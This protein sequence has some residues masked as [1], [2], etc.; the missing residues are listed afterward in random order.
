MVIDYVWESIGWY[1]VEYIDLSWRKYLYMWNP[2]AGQPGLHPHLPN[3][4]HPGGCSPAHPPPANTTFPPGPLPTPPG[5]PQGNPAFRPGGPCYLV[6]QPGSLGCQ[7]SGPYPC[8]Y[9]PPAPDMYPVNPLAPGMVA[10]GMVTDKRMQKKMKNDHKKQQ[11]HHKHG[12]QHT[13][14]CSSTTSR[15]SDWMQGLD[16]SSGLSNS[17]LPSSFR[18]HL[19][20]GEISP[21]VPSPHPHH[22][23]LTLLFS[24]NWL[25]KMG[26]LP[27]TSKDHL[28]TAWIERLAGKFCKRNVFWRWWDLN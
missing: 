6:P 20:L 21:R 1:S 7:P 9:P 10:P 19:V 26:E 14:S 5:G 16:P 22:L 23:C 2:S 25:G 17:A 27:W 8:P 13:S 24:P 28:P 4:E 12:R 11:K 15:D 18:C 3:I